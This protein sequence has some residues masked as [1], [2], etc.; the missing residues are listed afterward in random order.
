MLSSHVSLALIERRKRAAHFIL[1]L[2]I[3]AAATEVLPCSLCARDPMVT[4]SG[5]G[6]DAMRGYT[7]G[8]AHGVAIASRRFEPCERSNAHCSSLPICET[9]GATST[10]ACTWQTL[11][12]FG[13]LLRR[14]TSTLRDHLLSCLAEFQLLIS[15]P[16]GRLVGHPLYSDSPPPAS[17]HSR[18]R[19]TLFT[20]LR[21]QI[22]RCI[23]G[24]LLC[25]RRRHRL[26]P[27]PV[28]P[29]LTC[30]R[31]CRECRP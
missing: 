1:L 30:A 3:A 28:V 13:A 2:L 10:D 6:H 24:Q 11:T 12:M 21:P 5:V 31:L 4:W 8:Y 15:T 9:S 20:G 19:S 27:W 18:I 23:C 17:Q 25:S 29:H 7:S 22:H 26:R 16:C 14:H